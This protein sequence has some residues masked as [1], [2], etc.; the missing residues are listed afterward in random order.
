MRIN[1]QAVKNLKFS[2]DD[3]DFDDRINYPIKEIWMNEDY[4]EVW[5]FPNQGPSRKSAE[6]E[7][8]EYKRKGEWITRAGKILSWNELFGYVSVFSVEESKMLSFEHFVVE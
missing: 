6:M 2:S 5:F 7:K 8:S 3:N 1:G 4:L